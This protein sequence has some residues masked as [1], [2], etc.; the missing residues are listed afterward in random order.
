MRMLLCRDCASEFEESDEALLDRCPD[1]DSRDIIPMK[2][3]PGFIEHGADEQYETGV[4]DDTGGDDDFEDEPGS[5]FDK[6]ELEEDD[7]DG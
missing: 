3:N 7:E 4:S 2:T 5:I 6:R 1:C